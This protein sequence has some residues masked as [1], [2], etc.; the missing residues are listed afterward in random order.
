LANSGSE[1]TRVGPKSDTMTSIFGYFA[2]SAVSS[3]WVRVGSQLVGW[4]GVWP[5]K[6]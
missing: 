1:L 6:V 3:C 2:M 5:M 4:K